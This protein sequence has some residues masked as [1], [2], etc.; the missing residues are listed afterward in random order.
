MEIGLEKHN[1]IGKTKEE[2][3]AKAQEELQEVVEFL[4]NPK[5][6]KNHPEI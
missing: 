1:Y 3:I 4:K 2:A 6:F 5:K